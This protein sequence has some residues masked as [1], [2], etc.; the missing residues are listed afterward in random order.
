[1]HAILKAVQREIK[2]G[3]SYSIQVIIIVNNLLIL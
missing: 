3:G 2:D 1:M